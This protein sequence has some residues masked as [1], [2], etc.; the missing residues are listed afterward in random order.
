MTGRC[1]L[2]LQVNGASIEVGYSF[3]QGDWN[4]TGTLK[5]LQVIGLQ[6]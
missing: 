5:N 1:D 3:K 2:L 4:G 6:P